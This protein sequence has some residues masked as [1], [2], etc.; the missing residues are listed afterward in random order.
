MNIE[1]HFCLDESPQFHM[2]ELDC[3]DSTNN[4]LKHY[5][6]PGPCRLTLA[7]AEFQ[8]SGRG[9]GTNTW[10]SEHGSNL[11]FSLLIY[12]QKTEAS[13]VFALSEVLALSVHHAL[14][15]FS[16][17]F[18]IKWPNDIYYADHK[19]AGLLIENDITG[20]NIFRSV[21]GV[22]LN[23]NQKMF[24]SDAPNPISLSQ[25]L[26]EDIERRFVLEK[27]AEHFS[28]YYQ[29]LEQGDYDEIH[30][31]YLQRQYKWQKKHL[32][33]DEEGTFRATVEDVEPDGHLNLRDEEGHLRRYAFK[34]VKYIITT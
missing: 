20:K 4:F 31:R 23:I 26:G 29:M 9:A 12:P 3:I 24:K 16:S 21:M 17:G 27:V 8:T 28:H 18:T 1:R 10:E 6:P 25:I 22:G 5:R 34:E 7:T 32:F 30:S 19:V 13:K 33:E 14:S 11:L 15:E 2:I